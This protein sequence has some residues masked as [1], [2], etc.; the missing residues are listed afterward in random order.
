MPSIS[1][2]SQ[3]AAG[4]VTAQVDGVKQ[5]VNPL[6]LIM[7]VLAGK[8][9]NLTSQLVTRINDMNQTNKK[10]DAYN[11]LIAKIRQHMPSDKKGYVWGSVIKNDVVKAAEDKAGVKLDFNYHDYAESDGKLTYDKL[12]DMIDD[13]RNKVTSLN[14]LNSTT[15]LK[16]KQVQIYRD[17]TTEWQNSLLDSINRL[18]QKVNQ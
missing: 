4:I 16:I 10:A 2:I 17:E 13:V 18:F 15:Q 11:S 7:M 14:N 3:D 1:N 12:H 9:R 6:F 5:P 8:R